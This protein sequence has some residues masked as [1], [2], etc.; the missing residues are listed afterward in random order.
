MQPFFLNDEDMKQRNSFKLTKGLL[1]KRDD[2][3]KKGS[4][5]RREQGQERDEE[6]EP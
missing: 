3:K 2:K 6:E 4:Y 5:L 1:T